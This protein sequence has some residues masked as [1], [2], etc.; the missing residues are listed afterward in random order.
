M[1]RRNEEAEC[2]TEPDRFASNPPKKTLAFWGGVHVRIYA[3]PTEIPP[4][5]VGTG[6]RGCP[7]SGLVWTADRHGGLS[8]RSTL[9]ASVGIYPQGGSNSRPSPFRPKTWAAYMP[10][11]RKFLLHRSDNHS[12]PLLGVGRPEGWSPPDPHQSRRITHL[13]AFAVR[14]VQAGSGRFRGALLQGTHEGRGNPEDALPERAHE[15]RGN[16]E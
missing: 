10:P 9:P 13:P 5:S 6:P 8:L 14:R 16:P 15:E 11:L 4:S 1:K 2:T 7:L 12:L 3:A